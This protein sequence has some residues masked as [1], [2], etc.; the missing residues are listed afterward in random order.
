MTIVDLWE[1][2]FLPR[3]IASEL[4]IR[5]IRLQDS[6][7]ILHVRR[8]SQIQLSSFTMGAHVKDMAVVIQDTGKQITAVLDNSAY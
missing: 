6:T 2:V 4:F 8:P 7:N 1:R 3:L 5:R